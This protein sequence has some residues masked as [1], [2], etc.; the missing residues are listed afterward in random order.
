MSIIARFAA[1]VSRA[2]SVSVL[3][4]SSWF[5]GCIYWYGIQFTSNSCL[6]NFEA[7]CWLDGYI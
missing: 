7:S 6:W 5:D 2:L 4:C 1:S 3:S